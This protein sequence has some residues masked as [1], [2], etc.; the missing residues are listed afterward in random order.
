MFDSLR[1]CWNKQLHRKQSDFFRIWINSWVAVQWAPFSPFGSSTGIFQK[2]VPLNLYFQDHLTWQG[3]PLIWIISPWSATRCCSPFGFWPNNQSPEKSAFSEHP[4]ASSLSTHKKKNHFDVRSY[5]R[6]SRR[7]T[8]SSRFQLPSL[9]S[10]PGGPPNLLHPLEDGGN[11]IMALKMV[12]VKKNKALRMV[13][14]ERLLFPLTL[15]TSTNT[16]NPHQ[17]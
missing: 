16:S 1:A 15:A 7:S 13:D 6:G 3:L 9:Q 12:P 5:M 14:E 2:K 10:L 8:Q 11:T 4:H 17:H